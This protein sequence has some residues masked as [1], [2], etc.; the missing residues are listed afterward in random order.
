[1]SIIRSD[2]GGE[3]TGTAFKRAL[4]NEQIWQELTQPYSP[5]QNGISERM[6][7]KILP[8]IRCLLHRAKAPKSLWAEAALY[9]V[10][11]L[12]SLPHTHNPGMMSPYE[13]WDDV[14]PKL[15]SLFV[16]GSPAFALIPKQRRKDGKLGLVSIEGII[17]GVSRSDRNKYRIY[18][19]SQHSIIESKDVEIDE[20]ALMKPDLVSPGI[21]DSQDVLDSSLNSKMPADLID[22]S[23]VNYVPPTLFVPA[24]TASEESTPT[25]VLPSTP[26]KLPVTPSVMQPLTPVASPATPQRRNLV[27]PPTV[28]SSEPLPTDST[29]A[30]PIIPLQPRLEEIV[31]SKESGDRAICTAPFNALQ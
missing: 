24:A 16:W 17:V 30:P 25:T 26:T 11:V 29:V 27:T 20:Y 12:N 2:N 15:G 3:F 9:A 1:M 5:E 7:G 21:D 19:P 22:D 4:Q 6:N 8:M 18:V 28:V 31:E 23:T 10:H 13:G 14:K